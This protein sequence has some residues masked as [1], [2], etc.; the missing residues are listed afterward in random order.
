MVVPCMIHLVLGKSISLA[1]GGIGESSGFQGRSIQNTL[2]K[3]QP[4]EVSRALVHVKCALKPRL[5]VQEHQ[6]GHIGALDQLRHRF[7]LCWH[8]V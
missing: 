2:G 5:Q 6:V 4:H 7:G 1:V 8:F 3:W